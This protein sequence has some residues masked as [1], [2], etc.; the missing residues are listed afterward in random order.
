MKLSVSFPQ[1]RTMTDSGAVRAFAQAVEDLGIDQLTV[2]DHVL[3]GDAALRPERAGRYTVDDPFREPFI[4]MAFMASCTSSLQLGTSVVILPQ[5]QT[6][7]AAKQMAEIDILS[8]GRTMLGVGIGW[9]ELEFEALSQPFRN[10][11]RRI[12]E[13]IAVMRALWTERAVTFH[14]EW[15]HIEA[16]GLTNMPI[17]RPIPVWMGGSADAAMRRIARLADG[18]TTSFNT[19]EE[20]AAQRETFHG[21]VR[22]AGRDPAAVPMSPRVPIRAADADQWPGTVAAWRSI[23]ATHLGVSTNSSGAASVDE[24]ID[25]LRGF[26]QAVDS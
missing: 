23:G 8:G 17:Q 10:R 22:E 15:H 1:D 16:A 18:W 19:P 4:L 12:E 11:A 20:F 24:H 13:Q 21:Y 3:G 9:N 14:G 26:K 2:A 7:L 25:L 6:V 5:R